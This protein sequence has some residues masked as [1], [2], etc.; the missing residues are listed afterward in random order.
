MTVMVS[1]SVVVPARRRPVISA[2]IMEDRAVVGALVA[3]ATV[4]LREPWSFLSPEFFF[5]WRCNETAT[6]AMATLR[7]MNI[8][9]TNRHTLRWLAQVRLV[10]VDASNWLL[11]NRFTYR[12]TKLFDCFDCFSSLVKEN[13][14]AGDLS[15][16][17]SG[18]GT[19]AGVVGADTN[20][21]VISD[22][23]ERLP[24]RVWGG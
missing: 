14:V 8:G 10:L 9:M 2:L 11:D 7:R 18:S 20:S 4:V 24:D 21:S 12:F 5:A 1:R 3:A 23:G 22:K 17:V 15:M 13:L 6:S 16:S 19:S